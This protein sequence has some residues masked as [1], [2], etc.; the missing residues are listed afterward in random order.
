MDM[1]LIYF[2][3]FAALTDPLDFAMLFGGFLIRTFLG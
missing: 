3:S 2:N 1:F